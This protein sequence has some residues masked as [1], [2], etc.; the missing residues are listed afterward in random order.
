MFAPVYQSTVKI[1]ISSTSGTKGFGDDNRMLYL[2]CV[3]SI[4]NSLMSDLTIKFFTGYCIVFSPAV[5][6]Y[7]VF[8]TT[9]VMLCIQNPKKT[10]KTSVI[11]F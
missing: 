5:L 9:Y 3:F 6:L 8:I 11:N 7:C 10:S 1:A 2:R 4:P